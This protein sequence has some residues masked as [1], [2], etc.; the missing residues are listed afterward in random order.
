MWR[1]ALGALVAGF[2]AQP[3]TPSHSA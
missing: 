3:A 2:A 1:Q